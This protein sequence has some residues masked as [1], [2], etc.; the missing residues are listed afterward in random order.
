MSLQQ[1]RD[2]AAAAAAA[3][4]AAYAAP[5][6]GGA[7]AKPPSALDLWKA[8]QKLTTGVWA[9][10]R[11]RCKHWHGEAAAACVA[12]DVPAAL[13]GQ[14]ELHWGASAVRSELCGDHKRGRCK[15]SHGVA[16]SI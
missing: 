4:T 9:A 3:A 16:P 11:H 10:Q 14:R 1:P 8:G 13:C 7:T 12:A 15:F 6:G 2:G 5:Q